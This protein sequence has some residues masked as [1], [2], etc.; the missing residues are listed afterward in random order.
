MTPKY[1]GTPVPGAPFKVSGDPTGDASKVK[2]SGP[3]LTRPHIG[4]AAP[5]EVDTTKAGE[6]NLNVN[7]KGPDGGE[8]PVKVNEEEPGIFAC[9]YVPDEL[10]P[11]ELEVLFGGNPVRGS[12]F[13][14]NATPSPELDKVKTPVLEELLEAGPCVEQ[15]FEA[16]VDCSDVPDNKG[17]KLSGKI[18]TPSGKKE[19]VSFYRF[20]HPIVSNINLLM[21]G[22]N[23]RSYVLKQTCM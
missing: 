16:P 14:A 11:H 6:G 8:V 10:G 15:Q 18:T 23:K 4:H 12:P 13:K 19:K 5:F 7:A 22:G 2:C 20:C 17:A 3:G 9:E 1:G 21:T